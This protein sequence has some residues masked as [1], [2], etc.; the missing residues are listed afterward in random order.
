MDTQHLNVIDTALEECGQQPTTGFFRDGSC[1][2]DDQD[3]GRHT[4]CA[5]VSDEFL[6]YS[7]AQGNDLIT[8]AQEYGFPGLVAGDRW[9]LCAN[10][11]L[12]AHRAGVAPPVYLQATHRNTLDIVDLDTLLPYAVDK[13]MHA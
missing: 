10:R 6:Q 2:T 9:C 12:E 11:W 5:I 1:R 8:P 3:R 4:V 13:P 7:R